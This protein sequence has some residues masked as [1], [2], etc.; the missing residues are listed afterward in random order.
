MLRN[1]KNDI[2][3]LRI[4]VTE[5]RIFSLCFSTFKMSKERM[6]KTNDKEVRKR[7]KR[8]KVKTFP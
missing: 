4:S 6:D 7:M 8:R 3:I 2:E 1:K 5:Q